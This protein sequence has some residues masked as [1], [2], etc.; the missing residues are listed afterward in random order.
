MG[1]WI[2]VIHFHPVTIKT[3]YITFIRNHF[4]AQSIPT[5][6]NGAVPFLYQKEHDPQGQI[7]YEENDKEFNHVKPFSYLS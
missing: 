5:S 1:G 2:K 3:A 6:T 7:R 4:T